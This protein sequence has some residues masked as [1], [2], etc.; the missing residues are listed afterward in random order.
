MSILQ[1]A[2]ETLA[3]AEAD[4]K[5]LI[6]EA[7]DQG[8]YSSVET[9]VR[10]ARTLGAMRSE[11]QS[12]HE[13]SGTPQAHNGQ[14]EPMKD[15]RPGRKPL[16]KLARN[17]RGSY[18]QFA[19]AGD[20]LVK[21]AWSKSSGTEYEHKAPRSVVQ[22]LAH[23]LAHR[24][25]NGSMISMDDVLPLKADDGSQIPDYQAYV[26]LAWFRQIGAIKQKGRQGYTVKKASELLKQVEVAWGDLPSA[27][28][29]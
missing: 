1:R 5:R 29:S 8:E 23:A 24:S 18:P 20:A 6:G 17:K 22:K 7:A 9:L 14:P 2:A 15:K 25:E 21:I 28:A 4:L 11:G 16:R 19:R 12:P 10:W 3:S 13:T 26:G 27:T